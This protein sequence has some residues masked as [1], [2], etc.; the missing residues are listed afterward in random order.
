MLGSIFV[1]L[2]HRNATMPVT[3]TFM[4]SGDYR[5]FSALHEDTDK[6]WAWLYLED[7]GG[8]VSRTTIKIVSPDVK[9]SVYC[10]YRAI[11][12][13][14]IKRYDRSEFTRCIYF[15]N[16]HETQ[17]GQLDVASLGKVVVLSDWYRQA[18]GGIETT[19]GAR[20]GQKLEIYKP[21][22]ALWADLRA[23]CQHPEPGVRVATRVAILGTWLG[24]TALLPALVEIDPIKSYLAR[25]TQ[26]P[27]AYALCF[28]LLF[29][30]VCLIAGRGIRL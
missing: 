23:A 16:K 29:G 9:R 13:N 17:S 8:F 15:A 26:Q 3:K 2:W 18:L 22:F 6:G 14:F 30:V 12:S 24:V 27:E 19:H 21:R 1:N 25:C 7:T 28:S 4:N 10:E 20:D 11:D 5:V